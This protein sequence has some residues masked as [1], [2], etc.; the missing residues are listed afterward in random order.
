MA[1]KALEGVD[2]AGLD[3]NQIAQIARTG[4][5]LQRF[6]MRVAK[7]PVETLKFFNLGVAGFSSL[8]GAFSQTLAVLL[9]LFIVNEKHCFV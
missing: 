3:A 1:A 7:I 4:R 8:L 9:V 6:G 2:G 5:S